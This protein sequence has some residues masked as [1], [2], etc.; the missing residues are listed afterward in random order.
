MHVLVLSLH[1]FVVCKHMCLVLKCMSSACSRVS[2]D[3]DLQNIS[4]STHHSCT[5]STK[6][7]M[8]VDYYIFF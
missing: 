6:M 8:N 1:G 5:V 2:G 4:Y 7:E 3:F